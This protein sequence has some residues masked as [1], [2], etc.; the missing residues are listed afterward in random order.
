M[1]ITRVFSKTAQQALSISVVFPIHIRFH[2]LIVYPTSKTSS[3][4][5]YK[6]SIM[7][8]HATVNT[9]TPVN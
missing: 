1:R 4:E 7:K 9:I 3:W 2:S 6:F 5:E 8:S